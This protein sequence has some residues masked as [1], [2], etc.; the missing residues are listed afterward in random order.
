MNVIAEYFQ[1]E[2]SPDRIIRLL[3][4]YFSQKIVAGR[5]LIIFDEIQAC[6]RAL[7]SLKYFCEEAPEYHIAGVNLKCLHC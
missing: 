1:G 7:T 5:T 2:L 6:E 4:E 3:E